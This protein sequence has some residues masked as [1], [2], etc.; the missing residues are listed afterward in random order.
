MVP[1]AVL[2]ILVLAWQ[3]PAGSEMVLPNRG[4]VCPLALQAAAPSQWS[5]AAGKSSFLIHHLKLQDR[6]A[7][8][9][10]MHIT[11]IGGLVKPGEVLDPSPGD[12]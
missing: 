8:H 5:A 11:I 2:E 10:V 7:S 3:L 6:G 12:P 1:V 4:L 9:A